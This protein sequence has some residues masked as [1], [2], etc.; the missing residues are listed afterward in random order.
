MIFD[1]RYSVLFTVQIW[2]PVLVV[3]TSIMPDKVTCFLSLHRPV[4]C[5]MWY[6]HFSQAPDLSYVIDYF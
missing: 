1:A 3:C 6:D 4:Q 5:P 2:E